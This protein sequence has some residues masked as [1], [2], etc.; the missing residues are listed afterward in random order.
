MN[1]PP[2]QGPR[3]WWALG[4]LTVTMLVLGFDLTILNVALPT[5]AVDLGADTAAQQWMIDAFLVVFAA[6][7]LPAGLLGDRHGRRRMLVTGL[8][9][10]LAGSLLGMCADGPGLVIAARAVMGLGAALVSAL[11][12]AVLPSLFG[13]GERTRAIATLTTALAL[14]MP[15]GPLI[16]GWLLDHYWWGAIFLINVPLI[17]LGIAACLLLLPE[18]RNP[19]AP[20]FDP[21]TCALSAGGLGAL[22]LGLTEGPARGFADPLVA[23]ALATAVV[24]LTLLAARERRAAAPLLRIGLLRNPGFGWNAAVG[25]LTGFI[26]AALIFVL[27]QYLQSVHDH[28]A[29]GAGLRLMPMLGGVVLAARGCQPLVRQFG[30]RGVIATGLVLLCFAGVLGS[31]TQVD[32]GYGLTAVWLAVAGLGSGLALVP[33]TDAAID[34]LPAAHSGVGAGLLM[35]LRQVGGA[36]GVA[37]LGSLL[38][39]VYRGHLDTGGL[40]P[41]A[42]A[43]SQESVSAARLLAARTGSAE[44]TEAA[45]TAF[46]HAMSVTLYVCAIA[47]LAAALLAGLLLPQRRAPAGVLAVEAPAEGETRT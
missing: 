3:R 38:A 25:A 30:S 34:A 45:R 22:V 35:T 2:P 47:A 40:S 7:L 37:L 21:L 20:S 46:V 13:P 42:A 31:T 43:T 6:A 10:L 8:V 27:P 32:S 39:R 23:G 1:D 18:T 24:L 12:V 15:I 26:L 19:A 4:A 5:L 44:L 16:G 29:F 17:A 33:A 11:S 14:G 36:L 28:D 9:I 41:E